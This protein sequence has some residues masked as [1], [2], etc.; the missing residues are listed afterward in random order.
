M[1]LKPVMLTLQSR[2]WRIANAQRTGCDGYW[3]YSRTTKMSSHPDV[4]QVFEG[5]LLT[6]QCVHGEG[7][8]D[9]GA[10]IAG[11]LSVRDSSGAH[12]SADA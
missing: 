6:C 3:L 5:V 4:F 9:A 10:M 12:Y 1:L 7:S 8:S 11:K 2:L